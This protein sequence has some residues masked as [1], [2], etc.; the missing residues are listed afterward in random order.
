MMAIFEGVSDTIKEHQP[1]PVLVSRSL[2]CKSLM[3]DDG[4]LM[5][6]THLDFHHFQ[7]YFSFIM[8]V[9]F[10]GLGNQSTWREPQTC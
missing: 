10:I 4:R 2:K 8:A 1:M 9:S 3:T 5:A 6:I 7:Y